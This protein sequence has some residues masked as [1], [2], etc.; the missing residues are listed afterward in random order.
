M[1]DHHEGA[2]LPPDGTTFA[3]TPWTPA[4]IATPDHLERVAAVARKY[5]VPTMKITSGQRIAL[6]GIEEKDLE[7]IFADLGHD[8]D[9][10]SGP[11][12]HYVQACPGT[13][14]CRLATRTRF[15]SR[16]G[17]RPPLR[18]RYCPRS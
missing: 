17:S 2:I 7:G 10:T 13:E 16:S 11:C 5:P 18:E 8:A 3:V 4:G 9:R 15:R 1:A 6:V 14:I 12:L